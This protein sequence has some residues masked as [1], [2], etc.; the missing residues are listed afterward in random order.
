MTRSWCQG[1][2]GEFLTWLKL[3][4]KLP[5][6]EADSTSEKIMRISILAKV[7]PTLSKKGIICLYPTCANINVFEGISH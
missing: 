6:A 1:S 3:L 5:A 2:L 7:E 4:L